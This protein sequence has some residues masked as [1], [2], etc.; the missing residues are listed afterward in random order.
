LETCVS[1]RGEGWNKG[2]GW[3][4]LDSDLDLGLGSLVVHVRMADAL[5]VG[6]SVDLGIWVCMGFD[7]DKEILDRS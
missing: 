5:Y 3:Y 6:R 4:R 7:G 2:C 1:R